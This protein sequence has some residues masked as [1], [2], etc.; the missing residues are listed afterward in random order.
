MENEYKKYIDFDHPEINENFYNMLLR[1]NSRLR[2]LYKT[3]GTSNM[4]VKDYYS[5]MVL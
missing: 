4:S 5:G 3:I 1:N 2:N